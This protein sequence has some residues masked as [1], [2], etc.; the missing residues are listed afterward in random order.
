MNTNH[1]ETYKLLPV[2]ALA[3]KIDLPEDTATEDSR[4]GLSKTLINLLTLGERRLDPIDTL[5]K[6]RQIDDTYLVDIRNFGPKRLEDLKTALIQYLEKHYHE[7][8]PAELAELAEKALKVLMDHG[9]SIIN[10]LE[11]CAARWGEMAGRA[12]TGADE[13]DVEELVAEGHISI[14][15][16]PAGFRGMSEMLNK[17]AAQAREIIEA[18]NQVRGTEFE[19]LADENSRG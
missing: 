3:T 13:G 1:A 4:L 14:R 18:I 12:I 17:Q 6:L 7:T 11:I 16:T 10:A 8:L 2:R 19:E 9:P 15:P 5:G